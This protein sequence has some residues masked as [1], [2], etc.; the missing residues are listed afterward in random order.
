MGTDVKYCAFDRTLG[1]F[2]FP[3]AVKV[4]ATDKGWVED[5]GG[6]HH[7]SRE[8]GVYAATPCP[9]FGRRQGTPR[10]T[11]VLSA[12]ALLPV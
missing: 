2:R 8:F 9:S 11:A 4:E 10:Y 7:I 1:A 12:P 6:S 3:A 5:S